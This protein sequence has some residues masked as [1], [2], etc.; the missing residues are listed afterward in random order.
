MFVVV[1]VTTNPVTVV[2]WAVVRLVL[3]TDEMNLHAIGHSIRQVVPADSEV[4]WCH[5]PLVAED[6]DCYIVVDVTNALNYSQVIRH[7]IWVDDEEGLGRVLLHPLQDVVF[8]FSTIA[9]TDIAFSRCF[10][11]ADSLVYTP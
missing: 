10:R 1:H 7:E 6:V 8:S 2:E 9:Y 3:I 5:L 11:T 4:I